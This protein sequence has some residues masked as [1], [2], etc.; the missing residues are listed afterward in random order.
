MGKTN[1]K[2]VGILSVA[3]LVALSTA[4]A[5]VAP[6]ASARTFVG[7]QT[8]G[9]VRTPKGSIYYIVAERYCDARS[10]TEVWAR[11]ALY[12]CSWGDKL[13]LRIYTLDLAKVK[14]AI[15]QVKYAYDIGT[16]IGGCLSVGVCTA[17]GFTGCGG[18][19][20]CVA[21]IAACNWAL[22]TGGKDCG[23]GIVERVTG[24]PAVAIYPSLSEFGSFLID[25]ACR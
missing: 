14:N 9:T 15:C 21:C 1:Q 19:V 8:I 3:L 22:L 17:C 6:I 24:V 5:F 18:G 23:L 25:Q 10:Y 2:N 16:L 4:F 20:G 11:K 13:L 12:T 7:S